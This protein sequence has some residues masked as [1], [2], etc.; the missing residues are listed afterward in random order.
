MRIERSCRF[1]TLGSVIA[2]AKWRPLLSGIDQ[3]VQKVAEDKRLS[4]INDSTWALS[5]NDNKK[6]DLAY[7]EQQGKNNALHMY[8]VALTPAQSAVEAKKMDI[9]E[10][11]AH[12]NA[13]DFYETFPDLKAAIPNVTLIDKEGAVIYQQKDGKETQRDAMKMAMWQNDTSREAASQSNT[14]PTAPLSK[15]RRSQAR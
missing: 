4:Q 6:A 11:V 2:C 14:L 15:E 7:L 10:D 5:K 8:A 3:A 13:R 9:S 1:Q 12:K